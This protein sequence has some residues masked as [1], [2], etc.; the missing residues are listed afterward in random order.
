MEKEIRIRFA[1]TEDAPALLAIYTPY[2]LNTAITFEY[3]APTLEEFTARIAHTLEK[4]PYLV[5]EREGKILGY[6]YA[7]PFKERPAYDWAVETSIY[8]RSDTRQSGIG[9][10]LYDALEKVLSEQGI[11][12][13]EACIAYPIHE[14]EHLTLDSVKFHTKMGYRMVGRFTACGY[15]YEQWYD[16]VWMEKLIGEHLPVQLPVRPIGEVRAAVAE[17]YNFIWKG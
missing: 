7:S 12:N 15:K 14:D 13:M 6:A 5:A 16:M 9:R 4:F 1:C 3:E 17:K 10:C 11:L 2:V 8:V